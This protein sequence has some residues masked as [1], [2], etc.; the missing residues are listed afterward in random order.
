M[1]PVVIL[2]V[3][4]ITGVL[5]ITYLVPVRLWIGAMAGGA[6]VSLKSL[7]GMRLRRVPPE[8]IIE[9]L[10]SAARAGLDLDAA[11]LEHHF[12]AGGDPA[13]VVLAM[14]AA[15]RAGL[16]LTFEQA[17]AI[18]LSGR[19]VAAEIQAMGRAALPG[20]NR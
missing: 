2:L 20:N 5:I 4:I 17:A 18:D 14:L 8:K 12:L 13:K 11:S 16:D 9:P 10:I 15:D 6:P 7:V 1:E 19:D 3:L